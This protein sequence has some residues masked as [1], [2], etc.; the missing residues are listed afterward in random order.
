[1]MLLFNPPYRPYNYSRE[2]I[3]AVL[4]TIGIPNRKRYIARN[5]NTLTT[6]ELMNHTGYSE[7]T[8]FKLMRGRG[9]SKKRMIKYREHQ[10][11]TIVFNN[12]TGIYYSS[13]SQAANAVGIHKSSLRDYMVGRRKN[14]NFNR[15]KIV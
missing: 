2:E 6:A 4:E 1:M 15:F 5:W 12:E 8:L 10:E 9:I 3:T 7:S 11:T 14:N 13:I